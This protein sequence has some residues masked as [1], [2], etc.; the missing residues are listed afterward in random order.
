ME[1][2]LF[3]HLKNT[4]FFAKFDPY[5]FQVVE[6]HL[7]FRELAPKEVLFNEGEHGDYMAFLL[8]GELDVLKNGQNGSLTQVGLIKAGD[9]T[10]EMALLDTL[11]RSA[12]VRAV[13]PSALVTLSRQDFETILADHPRIGVEMLRGI[14]IILS[15]KL[16]RTSETLSRKS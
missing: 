3:T 11:T 5:M 1:N 9:N 16:R 6:Q 8:A 13:Q 2:I 7:K 12:T 14:A 4:P 15:L 10:G